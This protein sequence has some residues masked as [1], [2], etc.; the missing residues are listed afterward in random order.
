MVA[1][2]NNTREFESL[3][4]SL[5]LTMNDIGRKISSEIGKM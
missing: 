3:Q 5:S 4:K 2:I 1:M